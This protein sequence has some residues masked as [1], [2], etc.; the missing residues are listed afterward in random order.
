MK[1]FVITGLR[2]SKFIEIPD[3]EISAEEVLIEVKY[4][5]LCGS[6]LNT[7]RNLNPMVT[8]P[9]IPGHEIS[10]IIKE[11]GDN[12]PKSWRI[13]QKVTVSPYTNCTTCSACLMDKPNC[14]K[15]NQ[16]LGVQRDG[17]LTTFIKVPHTKLFDADNLDSRYIAL[18]EPLTVGSHA[19]DRSMANE[20]SLALVFG[21]GAVGL[22]AI[23]ALNSK[24][25]RVI[26]VDI[27]DE[28]LALAKE[29]GANFTINSSTTDLVDEVQKISNNMGVTHVIE[30]VGLAQ[31]F[32]M[33]VDLACFGGHVTY[34]G[35]AKNP[36]EYET[37]YFV[38]KELTIC[39]SRN[40]L[41]LNF[42]RVINMLT[43][44]DLPLE[45]MISK[46]FDFADSAHALAYWDTNPSKVCRILIKM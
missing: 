7:Y 37:K 27:D 14:C 29:F 24:G 12:V 1:A 20:D 8:L 30:A 43:T 5:G 36:V 26:A 33:S 11:M 2:D 28:K 34:I 38:Q 17:A 3:L 41:P 18:I 45:K 32:K 22:G 15:Y 10:G 46:E 21:V 6:D 42:R 40:A 9:R 13:G 25:A 44:K 16:T 35:Y 23:A 19:A 4:V 31:T 39:G